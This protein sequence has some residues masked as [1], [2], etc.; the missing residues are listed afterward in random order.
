MPSKH[1][2]YTTSPTPHFMVTVPVL[3]TSG[4]VVEYK[5]KGVKEN[6]NV[7][8]NQL[9]EAFKPLGLSEQEVDD[10]AAFIEGALRDPD[11][12]RYQP[13]SVHSGNCFPN[14]D[15]QSRADL[16]CN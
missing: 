15:P 8:D 9:D 10:I 7:A 3:R 13:A 6:S 1:L 11:L 14:N 2:S 4:K 16:G 12:M 5:N